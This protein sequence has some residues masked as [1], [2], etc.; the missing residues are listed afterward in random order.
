VAKGG[1]AWGIEPRERGSQNDNHSVR[2]Q[3]LRS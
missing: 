1:V 2:L 3:M